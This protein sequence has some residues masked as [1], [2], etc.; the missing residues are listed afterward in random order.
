LDK[1]VLSHKF[2]ED[3]IWRATLAHT[4]RGDE[5][6][7]LPSVRWAL[8]GGFFKDHQAFLFLRLPDTG[9]AREESPPRQGRGRQGDLDQRRLLAQSGSPKFT[10]VLM[11]ALVLVVFDAAPR[12]KG[13][14]DG[15]D[16]VISQ[17]SAIRHFNLPNGREPAI[18]APARWVITSG[19][20]TSSSRRSPVSGTWRDSTKRIADDH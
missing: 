14:E 7:R 19:A 20:A 2:L 16:L 18:T 8:F 17:A 5:A 1:R 13:V 15:H 3:R 11:A 10:E 6:E 4:H 12:L 9:R